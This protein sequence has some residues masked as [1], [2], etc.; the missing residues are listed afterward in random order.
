MLRLHLVLSPM[1]D[2]DGIS[3]GLQS[4]RDDVVRG[5]VTPDGLELDGTIEVKRAADATP[6][7]RGPLVHGPRGERFL[8]VTW[9]HLVDGR[10]EMFRRLKL[11][12]S[13]VTR[14]QWSQPGLTWD[15]IGAGEVELRIA[16]KGTDGTPAC[17]TAPALW[18]PRQ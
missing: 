7:F 3:V 1:P 5:R 6:D 2:L 13:P 12:L 4:G 18:R 16:G 14:A 9:G 11:Y 17:G 8:Y 10:H 15:D